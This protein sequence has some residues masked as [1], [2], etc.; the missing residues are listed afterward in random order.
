MTSGTTLETDTITLSD[1]EEF[2]TSVVTPG[3]LTFEILEFNQT[4]TTICFEE[5]DIEIAGYCND[6]GSATFSITNRGG[7]MGL[8]NDELF[9]EVRN[10]DNVLVDE[11]SV[12]IGE[13]QT[14]FVFVEFAD[15]TFTLYMQ[16]ASGPSASVSVSECYTIETTPTP[17]PPPG[18]PVCGEITLRRIWI[19][20][21]G[22]GS[23]AGCEDD[24]N[25]RDW[26]PITIG[27]G[28]C[29]D[30]LLYHTNMPG[31]WEVFRLGGDDEFP[32]D[33]PNL[34]QSGEQPTYPRLCTKPFTRR[35]VDC[36]CLLTV[37]CNWEIYIAPLNNVNSGLITQRVTSNE[38]AV[39]IDPVW[40]PGAD[41]D[42][43]NWIVYESAR[44]GQYDL[45]MVD[46]RTGY[47]TSTHQ[48]P[49]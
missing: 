15:G 23:R 43:G 46:V 45:W 34:S 29:P 38:V 5:A 26:T 18:D 6:D 14:R 3:V 37:T 21:S 4:V 31:N 32:D 17:T 28:V 48:Q 47:R 11:G 19:P 25:P 40:S 41:F 8:N 13:D 33:D 44:D 49:C 27:A 9:F 42:G 20:S 22:Y 16:L 39:D 36:I 2:S 7:D 12:V 1:G 10:Q 35:T 24:D 30:W